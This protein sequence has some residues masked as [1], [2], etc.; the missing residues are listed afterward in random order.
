M[1][2]ARFLL[3]GQ[4]KKSLSYIRNTLVAGGHIFVA[5]SGNI[6]NILRYVRGLEPDLIIV[7]ASGGFKELKQSVQVI[8]EE[9]LAACILLLDSRSDEIFDFLRKSRVATYIAKPVFEEVLL[10]IVDLTLAN[11]KRVRDYEG[12]LRHLNDTLESRKIIEKAKWL[13]VEQ[14]GMTELEAY[15]A[16][17][18]RSRDNRIAMRDIAEAIMLARG[19]A[20]DL[21]RAEEK[22]K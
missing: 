20:S 6:S 3:I 22:H 5:Y 10:Q 9:I 7:E 11:F 17:K 4:D 8:D 13:L 16:I 21:R 14:D 19:D 1:E 2:V 12:K 18:R 15:E